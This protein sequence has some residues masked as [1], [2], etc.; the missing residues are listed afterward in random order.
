[1][2]VLVTGHQGYIGAVLVPMLQREGHTV[3]GLD[4]GYFNR[5][6]FPSA[7]AA[8]PE[9]RTDIRHVTAADLEGIDAVIHLAALSNDP[10]GDINPAV[11]FAINHAAT[12]RLATMAKAAG[13]GRF[14]F[15]SS[16][17]TYGA[18]SDDLLDED[19]PLNPVTPY[20]ESKVRCER[21]LT[22]LADGSFCPVFLRNATAYGVSPRIRFDIV[23]NNLVAWAATTGQVRLKSDG[24]AWRPI[25]HI[26]D[27]SR[28]FIALLTADAGLVRARAYN[29]GCDHE[30]YRVREIAQ[31]VGEQVPDCRVTFAS[32]ATSDTRNY[33]VSFKRIRREVPAFQ[34]R[35]DARRG[36][37]EVYAAIRRHGLQLAE[38]EGPRFMRLAH[39]QEQIRSGLLDAHLHWVNTRPDA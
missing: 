31:L 3:V 22:D 9:I 11:T 8:T 37:G 20:G 5:C 2:K 38:F 7:P 14:L 23:L 34:P 12:V 24:S 39:L 1:M 16:C 29:I 33:R 4:T 15:S 27:I 17:S 28:A 10:L 30:N 6:D 19:A 35:W 21:D 13:I 18:G 32:D 36:I 26:E 25:V